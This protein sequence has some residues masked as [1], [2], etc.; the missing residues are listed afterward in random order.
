VSLEH[1][2][3]PDFTLES[4]AGEAVTLSETLEDGPAVVLIETRAPGSGN[5]DGPASVRVVGRPPGI[6]PDGGRTGEFHFRL[7]ATL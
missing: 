2:S 4:T 3:A 7:P 6:S 1:S 5:D